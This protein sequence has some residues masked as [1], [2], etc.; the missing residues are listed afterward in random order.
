MA[1]A[2]NALAQD[3][4]QRKDWL[5]DGASYKAEVKVDSARKQLVLTNGL[6]RRTFRIAPNCATIGFEN[7]VT[8]ESIIRGVKPEARVVIDGVR[9]DVG[10]LTGQRNYAFLKEEWIDALKSDPRSF[11]YRGYEIG[12]PQ[13]RL[14]WKRVRNHSQNAQWPP[15]GVS[16]RLDYAMPE[17]TARQ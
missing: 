10:G 8:G 16:L 15:K 7:L 6:L 4:V 17:A 3:D 13:K 12:K 14:D 1:F 2:K 11:Q 9:F 5:I